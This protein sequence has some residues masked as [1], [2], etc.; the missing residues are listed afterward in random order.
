MTTPHAHPLALGLVLPVLLG[1]AACTAPAV[2]DAGGAARSPSPAG[3]TDGTAAPTEEPAATDGPRPPGTDVVLS[4]LSWDEAQGVVVGGGYV[5]PVIEDGGT[6]TLRFDD[7]ADVVIASVEGLAD[8]SST[9]CGGL[10]TAPGELAPGRWTVILDY[11]SA[12]TEGR[13]EPITVEVPR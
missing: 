3:V 1:A 6:C 2:L 9:V 11:R 13:S 12:T 7:G 5:S 8:A 4:T 10:R